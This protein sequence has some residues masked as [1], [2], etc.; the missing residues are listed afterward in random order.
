MP[1]NQGPPSMP[2]RIIERYREY[3]QQLALESPP[4][5]SN[6]TEVEQAEEEYS[7]DVEGELEEEEELL[8][9]VEEG[10]HRESIMD[11]V[12]MPGDT[13]SIGLE[14]LKE[15]GALASWTVSTAKP[16]CGVEQLRDEDTGLYWQLV[17]PCPNFLSPLSSSPFVSS[18]AA[19]VLRR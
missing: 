11:G 10:G 9:E 18:F 12:D 1:R 6:A 5:S 4:P 17:P 3:A 7:D 8:E 16:G 2:R 19:H 14:D 15:I 13:S